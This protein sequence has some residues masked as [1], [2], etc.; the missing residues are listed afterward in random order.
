MKKFDDI[1]KIRSDV[2]FY[3][4][5]A[6]MQEKY[7]LIDRGGKS[8]ILHDDELLGLV[9]S[10]VES[11]KTMN[12]HLYH[13]EVVQV[14]ANTTKTTRWTLTKSF[15]ES[16]ETK[17][18]RGIIFDPSKNEHVHGRYLNLWRG[19]KYSATKG[20][21]DKFM[22]LLDECVNHN[23]DGKEYVLNYLAHSVQKP[24]E[25]PRTAV[26]FKGEQGTGKGTLIQDTILALT[27]NSLHLTNIEQI[28]GQF[29]E[30]TQ[31]C[32]YV[33]LDELS[34]GGNVKESNIL[35]TFISESSRLINGKNKNQFSVDV[36]QRVFIASNN[37]FVVKVEQGDR[38]YVVFE[39]SNKLKGN[40]KWFN[41]YREWLKNGGY[42]AIMYYL[43]NRDISAF[44]PN[45]IPMTKEKTDLT[46]KSAALPV[47]FLVDLL[48]NDFD[49]EEK[50]FRVD[51]KVYRKEMY[52]AF[53]EYAKITNKNGYIESI[54][55]FNTAIV[56][57]FNFEV[58]N[59]KWKENWKDKN[60]YFF[61][62]HSKTSMMNVI[63][64]NY[65]KCEVNEIFHNYN[66]EDAVE[67][68]AKKEVETM[69]DDDS[70]IENKL[71]GV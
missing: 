51:G 15:L 1:V 44:D 6:L 21:I 34:F 28:T 22:Y 61:K 2:E 18:L 45:V 41:D 37:D 14:S 70:T 46:L 63:A 52:N 35:K 48:N 57:I 68:E 42:E 56:K 24:A 49:T 71:L 17:R 47:K 65:F 55:E 16:H 64:K 19:F 27:T 29:N 13:D 23:K 36:Y 60:D 8:Y 4:A 43:M 11:F 50:L 66:C 39:T 33:F 7:S 59:E 3:D 62:I 40:F 26:V 58:E 20:N 54:K 30:H 31:A 53:I 69:F 10:D 25:I 12:L 9:Y 5:L 67:K 38:R 32:L